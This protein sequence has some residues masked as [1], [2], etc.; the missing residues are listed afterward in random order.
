MMK[1]TLSIIAMATAMVFGLEAQEI[2][3][4]ELVRIRESFART[5]EDI[6]VLS[7]LHIVE[8]RRMREYPATVPDFH[9]FINE[10]V[11]PDLY[12][13]PDPCVRMYCCQRMDV[14]HFL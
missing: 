9:E 4:E 14:V 10:G 8:D 7:H 11:W 5:R 3:N 13:V 2:G 12:I 1:K 6:A